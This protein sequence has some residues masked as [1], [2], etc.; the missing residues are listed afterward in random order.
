MSA[1]RSDYEED[2]IIKHVDVAL[3]SR[4]NRIRLQSIDIEKNKQKLSEHG[5]IL[6]NQKAALD[7]HISRFDKYEQ[8][9][10]ERHKQ[11]IVSQALNTEAVDNLTKTMGGA[12]EVYRTI[13]NLGRFIVWLSAIVTATGV[14]YAIFK[15]V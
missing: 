13:R 6:S 3:K 2:E 14:I 15:G 5:E 4:D 9:Q 11:V 12:A 7:D 1:S 8:V 10:A